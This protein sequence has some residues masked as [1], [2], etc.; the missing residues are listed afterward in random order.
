MEIVAKILLFVTLVVFIG[1]EMAMGA[2]ARTGV[3][4]QAGPA[5]GTQNGKFKTIEL[6]SFIEQ[7]KKSVEKGKRVIKMAA[8][9]SFEAR[10][11]RLPEERKLSYVYEV[12][13]MS[14]VK[15]LPEVGHRMFVETR[16][17]RIIPVYV[18]K[19][20]VAKIGKELKEGKTA[21]FLG[22]HLYSYAKGPAVM[23]V[24]FAGVK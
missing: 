7:E 6:D 23:V 24:D 1:S 15:P 21:R 22:Y 4:A 2:Q 20:T 9:V 3:G 17:G 12:L 10:M 14:G 13:E 18:E 8:P 11:K 19:Q 16:G 5:V